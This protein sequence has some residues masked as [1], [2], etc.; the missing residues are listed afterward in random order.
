MKSFVRL[1]GVLGTLLMVLLYGA[2]AQGATQSRFAVKG[3]EA[4][5]ESCSGDICTLTFVGAATGTV[6][7][8]GQRSQVSEIVYD[9]VVVDFSTFTILSDTFGTGDAT[10]SVNGK[11]T[12]GT[13]AGVIPVTTCDS[14]GCT[15]RSV[16]VNATW[17]AQG[18]P[19]RDK[20]HETV[21]LPDGTKLIF[22]G[23]FTS[24]DA[25]TTT[26]VTVDGTDLGTPISADLF[27]SKSGV[28]QI[29]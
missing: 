21:T 12:S 17:S 8:N 4:S 5:F 28:L 14:T 13:A 2:P 29:S 11:L 1:V 10:V 20:S 18:S 27:R 9:Q 7:E 22:S 25:T 6:R 23:N 24:R 16:T 26:T 19:L 3:G 15:S